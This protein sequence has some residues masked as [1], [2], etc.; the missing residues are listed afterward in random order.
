[1]TRTATV[2]LFKDSGKYYTEESWRVP[3]DAIGPYD[4][5]RSPDF[6]RIG[7]GAILISSEGEYGKDENWGFPHLFN[8]EKEKEDQ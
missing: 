4:M 6:R 2:V 3:E 5:D 1:M 7:H 8:A